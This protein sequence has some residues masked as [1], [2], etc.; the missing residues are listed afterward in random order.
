MLEI[1]EQIGNGPARQLLHTLANQTEDA[2][3]ARE[4]AGGLI[5][6]EH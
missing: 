3:L 2:Q 1:L 4:A 6:L 5:R